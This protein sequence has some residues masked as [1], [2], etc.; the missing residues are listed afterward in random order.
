MSKPPFDID[1][2]ESQTGVLRMRDFHWPHDCHEFNLLTMT[3]GYGRQGSVDSEDPNDWYDW[4]YTRL[5]ILNDR[6]ERWVSETGWDRGRDLLKDWVERTR[7]A[8]AMAP[9]L[10]QY[11]DPNEG[12]NALREY[13]KT[14]PGW[15][16]VRE[17]FGNAVLSWVREKGFVFTNPEE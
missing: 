6:V 12:L 8:H 13:E 5:H 14:T 4:E 7:E 11:S 17:D 3:H 16:P 1:F 2:E 9:K 15:T 10:A